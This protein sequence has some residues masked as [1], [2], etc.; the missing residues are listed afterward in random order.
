[1]LVIFLLVS[2]S[3]ASASRSARGTLVIVVVVMVVEEVE[4]VEVDFSR[5][6]V[7]FGVFYA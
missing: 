2:A 6:G 1:M 4:E 5:R 7:F 3:L